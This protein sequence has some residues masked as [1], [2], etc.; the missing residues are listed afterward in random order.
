MGLNYNPEDANKTWPDG[1][2]PAVLEKV[3]QK[4]SRLKPDGGGGHP[5]EQWTFRVYHPEG[6]DQLIE[7]Y[8]TIPA[9]TWKIKQLAKALGKDA[10]FKAGTFQAEDHIGA[11]LTA[12]L[13][14]EESVGFDDKNKIKKVKAKAS[15]GP[16]TAPTS[17]PRKQQGPADSL[18]G[19][20]AASMAAVGNPI[21][22]EKQFAD[23]DIPF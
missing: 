14:T 8:V 17:Q 5:M 16:T 4:T 23:D 19:R 18:R 3:E 9:C 10:D 11:G 21:S 15:A 20:S 1:E 13:I 6:K 22:E 2:Y 12:E 7:D